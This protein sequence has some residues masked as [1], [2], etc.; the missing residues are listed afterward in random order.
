MALMLGDLE[1]RLAPQIA[2]QRSEA[3]RA[4]TLELA[5]IDRYYKSLLEDS[6]GRGTDIPDAETRAVFESQHQRR[7]QEEISRHEVRATVHPVQ[8]SEWCVAAQRADWTLSSSDGHTA[9]VTAQRTLVG[10]GT[11]S[12]HC[13]T[14]GESEPRTLVVCHEDHAG[15]IGCSTLCSVCSTGFCREHG[16][17]A[18]H[19]DGAPACSTHARSCSSC[20]RA[21]CAAHEGR[22]SDGDHAACTTCLAGCAHCGVVVCD[23]HAS[24]SFI[25]APRGSRRLCAECVRHCEGGT[26][27][28][29]G[30]DEVARCSS[31]D[32]VV[33]E[34]HQTRCAVD[35]QVH[36]ST[37]MRRADRS[38]RLVCEGDRTVCAYE[39]NAIFA[40]DEVE[41][42]AS[43]GALACTDHVG[44]C[45]EDA[46]RHCT[47]H[48]VPLRDRVGAMACSAH[49]TVCHVD[50]V[51]YSLAGTT[52]CPV[53][54]LGACREHTRSCP[55]CGR[56]VCVRDL[57]SLNGGSGCRTC[58][59]LLPVQ[60][61]DDLLV[62]AA[63]V[64][65]RDGA[66]PKLWR[67]GRDSTH[68]V[69]ELDMGW[70][71]KIVFFLR[72]GSE[73]A[74]GV[75]RHSLLGSRRG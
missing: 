62:Q 21:H 74:E 13:P 6:A 8:L 49:Y 68:R 28:V 60:D 63:G 32:R 56:S 22:C 66:R 52:A 34:K 46:Q 18:C 39:P 36:C 14:C 15:C 19:V 55:N 72:H 38:R 71:R 57:V 43:C 73:R 24:M 1:Q 65:I 31:C 4:L 5:R 53:C 2:L 75:M 54:A 42:C 41:R 45:V 69:V 23:S 48:L 7:R 10:S 27:E 70:T 50:G 30:P 37:H 26:G 3:E 29:V 40:I 16:L 12:Y 67:V 11:W 59:Q 51:T 9:A 47:V 64:I 33:C 61:P 25:D 44:T 20:R 35:G 17:L 58:Q